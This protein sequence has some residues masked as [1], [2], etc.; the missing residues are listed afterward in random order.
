MGRLDGK[1]V[2]MTAAGAGIGRASALA[3]AREGAVVQLI[4][5]KKPAAH[6]VLQQ[7][8]IGDDADGAR[9]FILAQ[10]AARLNN[11]RDAVLGFSEQDPRDHLRTRMRQ[12]WVPPLVALLGADQ[13]PAPTRAPPPLPAISVLA[14]RAAPSISNAVP[15]V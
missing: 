4:G 12:G 2:V 15:V 11:R 6:Q 14:T 9:G 13:T 8:V 3:M 7:R 10:L 1:M 5:M